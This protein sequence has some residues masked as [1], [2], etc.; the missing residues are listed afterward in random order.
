MPKPFVGITP[1]QNANHWMSHP[2]FQ[3][4]NEQEEKLQ[5]Q[6]HQKFQDFDPNKRT[7]M[8]LDGIWKQLAYLNALSQFT[9]AR[10][11]PGSANTYT[12]ILNLFGQAA[13]GAM[14]QVLPFNPRRKRVTLYASEGSAY[15]SS[16]H[17]QSIT[18]L[19]DF[20]PGGSTSTLSVQ[21]YFFLPTTQRW[22]LDTTTALYA[23]SSS[24]TTFCVLSMVE[25]LFNMPTNLDRSFLNAHKHEASKVEKAP[26]WM[27]TDQDA[28]D[29]R[30]Q[31]GF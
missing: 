8:Q 31:G 25:E 11:T 4:K 17:Q 1:S 9:E 12:V 18:P 3:S 2:F 5:K 14:D 26:N 21:P 23:V 15:I 19:Q 30:M 6:A 29:R 28:V 20:T 13:D 7:A 24:N 22:P 10:K 27:E 16:D